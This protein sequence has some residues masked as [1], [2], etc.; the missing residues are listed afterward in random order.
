MN[1]LDNGRFRE[2]GWDVGFKKARYGNRL[3][4]WM[5]LNNL[6]YVCH[7]KEDCIGQLREPCGGF[8]VNDGGYVRGHG[9]S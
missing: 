4:G 8:G 2:A 3:G 1:R 5:G 7:L 9:L 6:R